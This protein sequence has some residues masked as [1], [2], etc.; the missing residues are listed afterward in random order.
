MKPLSSLVSNIN[1]SW[2]SPKVYNLL[3]NLLVTAS[4]FAIISLAKFR[5]WAVG[6]LTVR[7]GKTLGA[8]IATCCE[9]HSPPYLMSISGSHHFSASADDDDLV[10][11]VVPFIVGIVALK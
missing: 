9:L 3:F 10:G 5:S 2:V 4:F 8:L 1:D 7:V 11:N 6:E